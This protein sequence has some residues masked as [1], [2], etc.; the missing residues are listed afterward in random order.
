MSKQK[1]ED[2]IGKLK[3]AKKDEMADA[4]IAVRKTFKESKDFE[5]YA[6]GFFTDLID[7]LVKKADAFDKSEVEKKTKEEESK[8]K[9][10]FKTN[11]G[12]EDH[13][14]DFKSMMGDKFKSEEY[15][16]EWKSMMEKHP[17]FSNDEP[18]ITNSHLFVKNEKDNENNKPA[19]KPVTIPK[20][21]GGSFNMG[22]ITR[23]DVSTDKK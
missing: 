2:L 19:E 14:N 23:N 20:N 21:I 5:K 17:T 4:M 15:S 9:E 12:N 13:Y 7:P 1:Y 11:N 18:T 16:E 22:A 10:W 3:L 6:N 8:F